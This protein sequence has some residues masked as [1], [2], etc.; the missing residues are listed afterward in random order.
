MLA[1]IPFGGFYC[2]IHSEAIDCAIEQMF[3]DRDSGCESAPDAIYELANDG[4]DYSGVY[5]SYAAAY[6]AS[7]LE[8][9]GLDGEFESMDSPREYNFTTDRIFVELAR[10][11]VARL[12]R[13]VPRAEMDKAARDHFT[14]RDGFISGYRADWRDWGHNQLGTLVAAAAVIENGGDWDQWAEYELLEDC[15]CNGEIDSWI[16]ENSNPKLKRAADIWDYLQERAKRATKTMADYSA[17]RR[18]MNR[19][20]S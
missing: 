14:S 16:W 18:A 13:M 15:A 1:T 20:F 2:S 11:D 5:R 3:M 12:W 8:W 6:A 4:V 19:P 17:A 10:Q 9:L 7:F